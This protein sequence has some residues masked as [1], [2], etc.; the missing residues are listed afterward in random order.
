VVELRSGG[1]ELRFDGYLGSLRPLEAESNIRV[2]HAP[3]LTR[4]RGDQPSAAARLSDDVIRLTVSEGVAQWFAGMVALMVVSGVAAV[5]VVGSRAWRAD[6]PRQRP[7]RVEALPAAPV[8]EHRDAAH[9]RGSG[10][11]G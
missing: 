4:R 8:G 5:L 9:R 1:V 11:G 2:A 7:A 3:L 6:A 10:H